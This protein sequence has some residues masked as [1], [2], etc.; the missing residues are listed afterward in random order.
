MAQ[1]SL[2]AKKNEETVYSLTTNVVEEQLKKG[3]LQLVE[4]VGK[5]DTRPWLCIFRQSCLHFKYYYLP[6]YLA[7]NQNCDVFYFQVRMEELL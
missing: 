7:S 3:K 2:H 6:I 4:K 1:C 5:S